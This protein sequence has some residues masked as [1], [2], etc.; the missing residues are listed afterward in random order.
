MADLRGEGTLIEPSQAI[1]TWSSA[2]EGAAGSS[3]QECARVVPGVDIDEEPE[4]RYRGLR[5]RPL[6]DDSEDNEV[7]EV[8]TEGSKAV[9][10][11]QEA[12]AARG[13]AAAATALRSSGSADVAVDAREFL[14][15]PA[16]IKEVV[17]KTARMAASMGE[18]FRQRMI[19]A[20]QNNPHFAFLLPTNPWNPYYEHKLEQFRFDLGVPIQ[21]ED[22]PIRSVR[23]GE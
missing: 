14:A 13:S 9:R 7:I 22:V 17:D 12:E 19:K 5:W 23:T 1:V 2:L 21:G 18:Q 8:E 4:F 20:E 11:K 6:P 16:D 15:P 3:S 10:E